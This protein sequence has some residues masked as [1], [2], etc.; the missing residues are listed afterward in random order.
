[1]SDTAR[2]GEDRELSRA[3]RRAAAHV[4]VAVGV[5]GL[6]IVVSTALVLAKFGFIFAT[7]GAGSL[8]GFG[9]SAVHWWG[10]LLIFIAIVVVVT[11]RLVTAPSD[12]RMPRN[13]VEV[14]RD[15]RARAILARLAAL[16]DMPT[17]VLMA[18]ESESANSFVVD[19]PGHPVTLVATTTALTIC[20]NDELEAMFAHELFHVAHGDTAL[21][22]RLEQLADVADSR[23]P[24]PVAAYVRRSVRAMM[25]QRELSADRAAALL[26]GR[27]STLLA[28]IERCSDSAT[29]TPTTDLRAVL[30]VGFVAGIV[31]PRGAGEDTHPTLRERAQVLARVAGSLGT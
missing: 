10:A 21:T 24:R 31:K 25:R 17:P 9:L 29:L 20:P 6:F 3:A 28:A 16:A 8:I 12:A 13:L 4:G 26:T 18:L 11:V 14:D 19:V 23:A 7:H 27:P 5:T 22:R 1:V 15:D 30:T 2:Y